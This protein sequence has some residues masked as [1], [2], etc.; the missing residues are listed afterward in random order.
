MMIIVFFHEVLLARGHLM[1][2]VKENHKQA[3]LFETN[4]VA[5]TLSR[6]ITLYTKRVI[7]E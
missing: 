3:H 5:A 4:N 1:P 7:G 2:Q 6:P